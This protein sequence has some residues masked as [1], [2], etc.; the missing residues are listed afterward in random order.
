MTSNKP[1]TK[2]TE[3]RAAFCAR[4]REQREARSLSL[5]DIAAETRIPPRSLVSLEAG[6]FD[7]LP[8]DVFVRGFLRSYARCVGLDADDVVR[9]YSALGFAAAPVASEMASELL[10][11]MQGEAEAKPAPR[12]RLARGTNTRPREGEPVRRS[13][14]EWLSR[15]VAKKKAAEASDRVDTEEPEATAVEPAAA[16]AKARAPRSHRRATRLTKRA[17]QRNA[18]A[19]HQGGRARIF[20][21]RDFGGETAESRGNLTVAVII[22]VIVATITMSYLMRRPSHAGDGISMAPAIE[23]AIDDARA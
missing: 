16:R 22:L 14:A 18:A 11:Q 4:L 6:R 13:G 7:E 17:P 3:E 21:P 2:P 12:R 9:R 1:H 15:V 19:E 5:D 10:A 8:A 20:L 23:R